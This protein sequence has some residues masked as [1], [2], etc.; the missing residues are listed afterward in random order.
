MTN[1]EF[2]EEKEEHEYQKAVRYGGAKSILKGGKSS[3]LKQIVFDSK[4]RKNQKASDKRKAEIKPHTYE[5]GGKI[6]IT[7]AQERTSKSYMGGGQIPSYEKGGNTNMLSKHSEH[8]S[9]KHMNEMKSDMK[10]G[11]SFSE[12]HSKALKKVGK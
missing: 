2:E 1:K 7:N 4:A 11:A 10:K 6:P 9:K 12:S 8:H 3:D 5:L